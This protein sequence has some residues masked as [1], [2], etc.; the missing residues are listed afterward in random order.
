MS[1]YSDSA[2]DAVTSAH[3]VPDDVRLLHR[4]TAAPAAAPRASMSWTSLAMKAAA[5]VIGMYKRMHNCN[6]IHYCSNDVN[7][8]AQFHSVSHCRAVLVVL[9]WLLNNRGYAGS[10]P[11]TTPSGRRSL[12]VISMDGFRANYM[13]SH[14]QFLPNI[15]GFFR[16]GV[17]SKGIRPSFPSLTFPNHYTIATGLYPSA[18]GII[19]NSFINP[20]TAARFSM[21]S[22]SLEPQWWGGEPLWVTARKAGLNAYVYFWPGS[23]VELHGFRPTQYRKCA[24]RSLPLS[25]V[26]S[27]RQR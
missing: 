25:F 9:A 8:C 7:L 20:T 3:P 1:N 10:D 26:T 24:P 5:A 22:G 6:F 2:V 19:A 11:P 27:T 16:E 15:R 18:H 4:H 13:Q 12:L 21:G 14:A 23:E 17:K